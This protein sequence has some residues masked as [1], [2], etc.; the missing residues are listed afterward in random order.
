MYR[1][2]QLVLCVGSLLRIVL[3]HSFD[4]FPSL[5]ILLTISVIV[6]SHL[7]KPGLP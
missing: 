5:W 4:D 2:C 3:Y 7:E 6:K 1:T